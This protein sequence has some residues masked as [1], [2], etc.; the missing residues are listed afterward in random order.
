MGQIQSFFIEFLSAK[1]SIIPKSNN[2][3][4]GSTQASHKHTHIFIIFSLRRRLYIRRKDRVQILC[5][6]SKRKYEN[7]SSETSSQQ[8]S[9]KNSEST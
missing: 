9:V 7:I 1:M 8:I 5:Q 3:P 6:L 2:F 4:L